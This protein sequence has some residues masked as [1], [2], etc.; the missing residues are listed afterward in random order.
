MHFVEERERKKQ[1][2]LSK[3]NKNSDIQKVKLDELINKNSSYP[4]NPDMSYD[5]R[6]DGESPEENSSDF[7]TRKFTMRKSEQSVFL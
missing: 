4:F 6:Q 2:I 7:P 1:A 3:R 5:D